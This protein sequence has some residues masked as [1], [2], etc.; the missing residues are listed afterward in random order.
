MEAVEF[1]EFYFDSQA[2]YNFVEELGQGGMGVVYLAIRN[3]GGVVD[4]VVLKALKNLTDDAAKAV[5]QETNLAAQLRHENIVK[6]YGLESLPVEALPKSFLEKMEKLSYERGSEIKTKKLRRMDF[7]KKQEQKNLRVLSSKDS[8]S[9]PIALLVTDYVDGVNLKTFHYQHMHHLSL[10]IPVS[11]GA[12]IISRIAR[13]LAYAHNYLIHRNLSLENILI[14]TQGTCKL[15]DF[16]ISAA[17]P[18]GKNTIFGKLDF[19]APE[20]IFRK[21][22][23]ERID[24][25]SLGSIAYQILTGIPLF[26]TM[27]NLS[28]EDQI[29]QMKKQMS[30]EIVPPHLLC[31]DIPQELSEIVM[32]M[33][34]VNP[35]QRYQRAGTVASDLEKRFL[36]AKGYGPTNNSLSTYMAIFEN[37]FT[38]YNEDQVDQLSFLKNEKGEIS[39]KRL[40]EAKAYTEKGLKLLEEKLDK[41]VYATFKSSNELTDLDISHEE[42]LPYLK[43]K[44]LDNVIE[45]F[46]IGEDPISIG[47][48]PDCTVSLTEEIPSHQCN[49]QKSGNNVY[50]T[51]TEAKAEVLVNGKSF[52]EKELREGDKLR[53]GSHPLFFIRQFDLPELEKENIFSWNSRFDMASLAE[54]RDFALLLHPDT[55]S[56][57]HLAR[58]VDQ[59]LSRTHLSEVKL[60]VITNALIEIIQSLCCDNPETDFQIRILITPV[61]LIFACKGF[62]E[63]G[64]LKLLENF[65]KHRQKLASLLIQN[66]KSAGTGAESS[67]ESDFLV[68]NASLPA[69]NPAEKKGEGEFNLDDFDPSMLAATLFVHSFERIEFKREQKELELAVYL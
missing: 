10:L 40:F 29:A 34:A 35:D 43:V 63:D 69:K 64:Y 21:A 28:L 61:R 46:L 39:L 30:A 14:N 45:S 32:K 52:V 31:K 60:G 22:L 20:Q 15:S 19:L 53:L 13:G 37:K 68:S 9:K 4:Y 57:T 33:L 44:Y 38:M 7:K 66:E 11:I 27:P 41:E 65:K 51:S 17:F 58:L 67:Q 62:P 1:K 55:D 3:L 26:Q 6:T 50:L 2:N 56:L 16:G 42:R 8:N 24:V 5:R 23:D 48:S 25:F 49:I 59:I 54:H 12:F 47:S 18:T 36:Y